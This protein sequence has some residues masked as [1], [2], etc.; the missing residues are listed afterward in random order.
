VNNLRLII[1]Q[2]SLFLIGEKVMF[3]LQIGH[4]SFSMNY[5]IF[6]GFELTFSRPFDWIDQPKSFIGCPCCCHVPY[7]LH[8]ILTNWHSYEILGAGMLWKP[9][10]TRI[11]TNFIDQP[12]NIR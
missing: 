4:F 6:F 9:K 7:T 10:K 5:I 12:V 1:N 3:C 8:N 2:I 11:L